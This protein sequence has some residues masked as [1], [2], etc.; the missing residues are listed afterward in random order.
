[1]R[2]ARSRSCRRRTP[3]PPFPGTRIRASASDRVAR[4]PAA[5]AASDGGD[6]GNDGI[7]RGLRLLG[8]WQLDAEHLVRPRVALCEEPGLAAE[9][10][11]PPLALDAG[12]VAPE[13]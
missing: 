10:V 9:A 3:A 12:D 1:M 7:R 5:A 2:R 11:V 8:T 4:S 6:V 13:V